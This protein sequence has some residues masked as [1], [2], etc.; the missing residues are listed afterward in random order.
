MSVFIDSREHDLIA[1]LKNKYPKFKFA[2]KTL[3]VGDIQ[4]NDADGAP[5]LTLER[6]TWADLEASIIDKRWSEQGH[7]LRQLEHRY[8]YLLEGRLK[9]ARLHPNAL[10]GAILNA[11]IRDKSQ[12]IMMKNIDDTAKLCTELHRRF[13]SKK[14]GTGLAA[15][16]L[17]SGLSKRK[18]ME[19]ASN[20]YLKQLMCIP[21]ISEPIAT[22]IAETY[23]TRQALRDALQT[24]AVSNLMYGGRRLGK[25]A[26]NIKDHI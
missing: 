3:S 25:T 6:K 1:L 16:V 5:V 10:R 24:D 17:S 8:M 4:L 14:K 19:D 20:I 11:Q 15:P 12:F 18:R 2:I 7:R 13:N 23:P 9:K 26:M 21:K 22:L